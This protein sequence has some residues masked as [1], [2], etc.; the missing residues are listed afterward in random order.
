MRIALLINV[1]KS[2]DELFEVVLTDWSWN[3][4]RV[5]N[6]VEEFSIIYEL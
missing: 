1:V 6:V 2:R 4:S 5:S 3:G